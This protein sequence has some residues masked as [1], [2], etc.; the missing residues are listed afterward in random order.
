MVR[1]LLREMWSRKVPML[2]LI[3]IGA[4]GVGLFVGMLS[5]LYDLDGARARFYR[6]YRLA[7]FSLVLKRLPQP[8][9]EEATR[10]ENVRHLEGRVRVEARIDLPGRLEPI[11]ST[12]VSLPR[13]RRPVL[14]DVLLVTGSWFSG[15]RD[16]EVILNQAFARENGLRPGSRIDV[17]ILGRLQSLLVV[18]TAMSPEFV[19]VLPPSGGIVPDP[20]RTG[21]LYLPLDTLQEWADLDGACNEVLGLAY[22][23]RAQPL[24]N[25]LKRLEER[26]EPYGVA[27]AIP[28]SEQASVQFLANELQE[29]KVTSTVMPV[30]CLGV[31]ALVLNIVMGRTV[32]QQRPTIGTL[33]ALGY[34]S[35]FVVRHFLAYGALVGL[36][37]AAGGIALGLWMQAAM[38]RLYRA[39]FEIPGLDPG[40]YPQ[41]PAQALAI[42]LAFAL[43]GTVQAALRASALEPAEAMRPPPPEK[44]SRIVLERLTFLWRPLPFRWKFALRS[45]FR[46]PFRTGV[47]IATSVV[48]TALVVESLCMV[49]GLRYMIDHEFQKT[50]HQDLTLSLREP[51]GRDVVEEIRHLPHVRLVEPQL[52]VAA[53]VTF[54]PYEKRLGVTGLPRGNTLFTPLAADGSPLV[55]PEQGLVLSRKLAEILH[56]GPGATVRLRP[57]IAERR[58]AHAQVVAVVDT[59]M[60]LGAYC[61]L[62]YLSRLLGE[63]WVA[64]SV[65]VDLEPAQAPAD[66]L[67]ELSRRPQVVGI[68][69]R[70]HALQK[71]DQVLQESLGT[72]LGILIA[73][74][75]LLAFGSVLNT[76]IVSLSERRREVGTLRVLGWSPGMV[77]RIFALETALANGFGILLGLVAG[78][79]LVHLVVLGYSSELFRMP[80]VIPPRALV[81]SA[82]LMA[83]FVAAAEVIVWRLIVGLPWLEVFKVRE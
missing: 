12:A 32:A 71:I 15:T 23:V 37:S 64:N 9:L 56:V 24:R 38:D 63:E 72:S 20:A 14:N 83:G 48:A 75:G 30:I 70:I 29:L 27:M 59:Y 33:R 67:R 66:L 60:G 16:D 18:G 73:F 78:V 43:A 4:V 68:D 82:L 55:I 2:L 69:E 57:L 1:S 11:T 19:Y 53:D 10:V 13:V 5:V 44:G 77:T 61:R 51:L 80:A 52:G 50:S 76:A 49:A 41:V 62:E 79:G 58:V 74:S 21:V 7:D 25:T 31:V 54:G 65:L 28:A 34:T 6:N 47:G 3:A 39:Y 8:A 81:Q 35:G 36:G 45:L 17:L 46:N 40:W 26:L 22:D 42:S